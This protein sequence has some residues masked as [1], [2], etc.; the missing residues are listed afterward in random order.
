MYE[1]FNSNPALITLI[2]RHTYRLCSHI[3]IVHEQRDTCRL[4]KE[5]DTVIRWC[6]HWRPLRGS[7]K[8]FM[9]PVQVSCEYN[10][11]HQ[12][13]V[14][15]SR[16]VSQV[17]CPTS[18]LSCCPCWMWTMRLSF[19]LKLLNAPGL[20]LHAVSSSGWAD[21]YNPVGNWNSVTTIV[22]ATRVCEIKY[23]H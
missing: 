11:V 18:R 20:T 5:N 7:F 19:T 22:P 23:H 21:V 8:V 13:F 14:K 10:S 1:T 4:E 2:I 16:W 15:S 12:A 17:N 3:F 9:L 6:V